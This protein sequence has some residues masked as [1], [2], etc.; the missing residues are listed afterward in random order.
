MKD[1][2]FAPRPVPRKSTETKPFAKMA[3]RERLVYLLRILVC[4]CTFGFVY[5]NAFG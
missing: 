3:G 4:I 2:N 5:P 1:G